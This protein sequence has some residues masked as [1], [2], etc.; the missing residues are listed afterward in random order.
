MKAVQVRNRQRAHR[1]NVEL[2][3]EIARAV[4]EEELGLKEYELAVH[5]VS[6]GKMA[7]MNEHF[8]KHRGSTDVI[9]FDYRDGYGELAE[10]DS[11]NADL[12]GEIYISVGDAAAQAQEFSTTIPE[13]LARY[14]IHGI[15]HLRGFD[16]IEPASRRMMKR[17]ENRL[18]RRLARRFPV[19]KLAKV[20]R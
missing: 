13:E 19:A 6:A 7:E 15:L 8:L 9:T 10:L 5:F 20:A 18:V 17:E 3:R 1:I 11:R 4:L 2:A 12:A 14:V 16:D